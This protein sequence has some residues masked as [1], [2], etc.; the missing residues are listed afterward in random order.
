VAYCE[1]C[2]LSHRK[3]AIACEACSHPLGSAPDWSA[4]R[5]SRD[6]HG[7]QALVALAVVV[8]MLL[9][10]YWVWGGAGYI[11]AL[12]PVAWLVRS[13]MRYRVLARA[14]A[15]QDE[16]P[17]TPQ[18][19]AAASTPR[20]T[21]LR[22]RALAVWVGLTIVTV[23]SVP[24]LFWRTSPSPHLVAAA[25]PLGASEVL[26]DIGPIDR[27]S[28][29][30]VYGFDGSP[31]RAWGDQPLPGGLYLSQSGVLQRSDVTQ[32]SREQLDPAAWSR[33]RGHTNFLK[34]PLDG[35]IRVDGPPGVLVE[36]LDSPGDSLLERVQDEGAVVWSKR[37]SALLGPV[38]SEPEAIDLRHV[39]MQSDGSLLVI[40]NVFWS[41]VFA[42]G[43]P[44]SDALCRFVFVDSATGAVVRRVDIQRPSI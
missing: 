9:L 20:P 3:D 33:G 22:G 19:P 38:K 14:V 37:L 17:T 26:L 11:L 42:V 34:N 13:A 27:K 23:A 5:G 44:V 1:V 39:Q 41:S 31:R 21:R 40:L 7:R 4:V 28:T 10:N 35:V 43:H 8:G 25:I 32:E 18:E 36:R 24:L 15:H 12:G 6:S 16:P 2:R 30:V 29:W